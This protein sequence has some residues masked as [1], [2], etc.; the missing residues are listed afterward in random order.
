M[1]GTR[2]GHTCGRDT[3]WIFRGIWA[4]SCITGTNLTADTHGQEVLYVF[5]VVAA[6]NATSNYTAADRALSRSM[7]DYW[8]VSR[9]LQD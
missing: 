3:R 2:R 7:M 8:W 1:A 4:V 9:D 5:G 6:S